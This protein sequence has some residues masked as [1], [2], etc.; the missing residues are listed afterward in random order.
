M[1]IRLQEHLFCLQGSFS[2]FLTLLLVFLWL[3][4]WASELSGQDKGV[5][6]AEWQ[7]VFIDFLGHFSAREQGFRASAQLPNQVVDVCLIAENGP[8]SVSFRQSWVRTGNC[9]N[10]S[11]SCIQGGL[12]PGWVDVNLL[13]LPFYA[14]T[15]YNNMYLGISIG[16]PA[17]DGNLDVSTMHTLGARHLHLLGLYGPGYLE[18][19]FPNINLPAIRTNFLAGQGQLC[20]RIKLK[21]GLVLGTTMRNQASIYFD[22][23]APVVTNSLLNT[24]DQLLAVKPGGL[25]AGALVYPNPFGNCRTFQLAR[26]L[27]S[28]FSFQLYGVKEGLV[29]EMYGLQGGATGA[30]PR[31]FAGR[32]VLF[33]AQT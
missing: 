3:S 12:C 21:P 23:D 11:N 6:S 16:L 29:G 14:L 8:G 18:W 24:V 22:F 13:N 28:A 15:A 7:W 4:C 17:W 10:S 19:N 9:L 5:Q 32:V 20:F 25:G 31:Q 1:Q 30:V 33:Q 27:V 2:K 26:R